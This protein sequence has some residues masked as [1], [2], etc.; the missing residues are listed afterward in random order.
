MWTIQELKQCG[1]RAFKANYWRSVL[2]AFLLAILAG[3]GVFSGSSISAG[4]DMIEEGQ[5]FWQSVQ[6]YFEENPASMIVMILTVVLGLTAAVLLKL[7]LLNPLEVGCNRFFK[8]NI[9]A[10][11]AQFSAIGEGFGDYGHVFG[12]LFLRDLFIWLW[13]LLLVI[14]GIIQAYA[15]R[16]VPYILKDEPELSPKEVLKRSK[17]M[18]KGSKWHTF[19]LDLSF[20]GWYLLGLLTMGVLNFFW[21]EP[22]KQSTN[23]ALYVELR[24]R[25]A[26]F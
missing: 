19:L 15:Y 14:P 22:Y 18:M 11:P 26:R 8:K 25:N 7:F 23:A 12:T 20:L 4:K 16:M 13:S 5:S 1:K 10:A 2:T 6:N 17:E 24:D 9:E 3:D 21:T